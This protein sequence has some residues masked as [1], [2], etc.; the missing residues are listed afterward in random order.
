MLR[1]R[2]GRRPLLLHAIG[3]LPGPYLHGCLDLLRTSVPEARWRLHYLPLMVGTARYRFLAM[4]LSVDEHGNTLYPRLATVHCVPD[5]I[6]LPYT[7]APW[8]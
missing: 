1:R 2:Y 6:T 4:K 8:T 5:C 3:M 7:I